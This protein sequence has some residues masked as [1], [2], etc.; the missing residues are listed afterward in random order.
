MTDEQVIEWF[1]NVGDT[2]PS[3]LMSLVPSLEKDTELNEALR[4]KVNAR[5]KLNSAWRYVRFPKDD[6]L[7]VEC[8][9]YLRRL[10]DAYNAGE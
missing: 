4:F 8:V 2:N 1:K 5:E 10:M 3:K 9:K 6:Y 7:Y